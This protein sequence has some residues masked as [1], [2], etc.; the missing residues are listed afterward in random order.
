MFWIILLI[1]TSVMA[2]LSFTFQSEWRIKA[3]E[4]T[5]MEKSATTSGEAAPKKD[6]SEQD[7]LRPTV[8]DI[9]LARK[10]LGRTA[11]PHPARDPE[12][13]EKYYF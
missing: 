3:G 4:R 1:S 5:F 7:S 2:W 13:E 8:E 12:D 6:I 10:Y 11:A 9:E